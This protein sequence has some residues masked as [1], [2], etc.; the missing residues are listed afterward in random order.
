MILI[1]RIKR[2]ARP[3]AYEGGH[4]QSKKQRQNGANG[5]PGKIQ[6]VQSLLE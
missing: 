2:F 1:F 5:N 4:E 6:I 3:F